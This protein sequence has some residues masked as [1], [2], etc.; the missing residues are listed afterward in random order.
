MEEKLSPEDITTL[1]EVRKSDAPYAALVFI[2]S[3]IVFGI[4]L[5]ARIQAA[6]F[7]AWN[8][9]ILACIILVAASS[10]KQALSYSR[11]IQHEE[12]IVLRTD[13]KVIIKKSSKST[14]HFLDIKG[15]GEIDFDG[16]NAKAY[17]SLFSTVID[18]YEIHLAPE[19]EV[20]LFAKKIEQPSLSQM[21]TLF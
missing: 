2:G 11:D 8:Y 21:V 12:K 3:L 15:Y 13:C 19:S 20:I 9:L 7:Q 10:L 18:Y 16:Y 1:K 17:D 5:Y 6:E 4:Y 14:R